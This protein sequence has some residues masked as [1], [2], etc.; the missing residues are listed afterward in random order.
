MT[1]DE[2]LAALSLSVSAS[3]EEQLF[4]FEKGF[5][6]AQS[7]LIHAHSAE[8]KQ[9]AQTRIDQLRAAQTVLFGTDAQT[10][11]IDQLPTTEPVRETKRAQTEGFSMPEQAAAA[12]AKSD[13]SKWL[14]AALIVCAAALA[15]F[16][17]QYFE[18]KPKA[19][20]HDRMSAMLKNSQ[21]EVI[22]RS[23]GRHPYLLY[24]AEVFFIQGD[25]I[26][27]Q[28]LEDMKVVLEPGRPYRMDPIVSGNKEIYSGE[29]LFYSLVLGDVDGKHEPINVSG[30]W[31][32]ADEKG[33]PAKLQL[34]YDNDIFKNVQ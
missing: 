31:P 11:S 16:A 5:E 26:A 28:K 9:R 34:S 3:R 1:K 2:A 23:A 6:K 27:K 22:N 17:M 33:K 32:S 10:F 30:V 4:Q 13:S 15:F 14:V 24:G 7:N 12:T 19:E 20:W 8:L 21:F 29:V 25:T 18:L